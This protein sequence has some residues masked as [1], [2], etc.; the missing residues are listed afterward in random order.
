MYNNGIGSM[1]LAGVLFLGASVSQ[2]Q[3]VPDQVSSSAQQV[4]HYID[5]WVEFYPSAAFGQ[6]L[7]PAALLFEDFSEP[8]VTDWIA[9]NR[10]TEHIMSSLPQSTPL[11]ERVDARVLLRQVRFELGLWDEDKVLSQQPQWYVEQISDALALVLVSEKLSPTEKYSAVVNRMA[12]IGALVDVGIRNLR[13]GNPAR[14][15]VALKTLEQTTAYFENDLPTLPD[16]W[17]A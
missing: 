10:V 4:D 2:A 15:E 13:D 16:T 12:G 11:Q 7:K 17:I 14:I 1:L 5:R 3:A 9:F 6:G 8:R